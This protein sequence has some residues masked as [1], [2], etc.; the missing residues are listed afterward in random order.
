MAGAPNQ[1]FLPGAAL[2]NG[3]FRWQPRG[4]SPSCRGAAGGGRWAN[5]KASAGFG[6]FPAANLPPE[7]CARTR[8]YS[9]RCHWLVQLFFP[10]DSPSVSPI[11]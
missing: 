10:L 11:K 7:E 8:V 4:R 2:G 9:T 6:S 1:A 3:R 5:V